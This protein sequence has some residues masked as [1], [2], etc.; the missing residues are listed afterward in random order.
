MAGSARSIL[1]EIAVEDAAGARAAITGGADRLELCAALAA[2]GITP[3]LGTIRTVCE[4]AGAVPVVV[5]LRPRAGSFVF[6][7][8]ERRAMQ[9]DLDAARDAGARGFVCGALDGHGRLDAAFLAQLVGQAA[10]LPLTCHRAFDLDPDPPRALEEVVRAGVARVLTSGGM[11]SALTG[12]ERIADLVHRAGERLVVLPGG[13]IRAA[14]AA[15]LV[16]ATGAR[17]VHSSAGGP[18]PDTPFGRGWSTDA[19]E[20]ARLRA[21]LD[22]GFARKDR[23]E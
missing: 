20:V 23:A 18:G 19:A 14:H 7:A 9:L 4:T 12:A 16:A 13:G 3:S 21:A 10:P 5:M 15:A 17:E 1:L 2:G 6:D 22:A 8:A 11:P